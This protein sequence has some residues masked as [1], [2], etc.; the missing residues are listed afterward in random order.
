MVYKVGTNSGK[1]PTKVKGVRLL[2]YEVWTGILKRCYIRENPAYNC[3]TV[4]QEW[5]HYDNFYETIRLVPNYENISIGW[6]LDKDI[7]VK[8]NTTYSTDTCC[9]VP[10]EINAFLIKRKRDRGL[11]PI[12]VSKKGEGFDARLSLHNERVFL[13]HFS[14]SNEAFKAY[15]DAK[16]FEI[17]KLAEKWKDALH[18]RTYQALLNY[19]VEITD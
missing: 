16:E 7:L 4:S 6:Q 14:S 9:F 5:L 15:K 13:G 18:P 17:K 11:Y 2:E 19:Q 1:Y 10:R 8:N 3:C 12:G